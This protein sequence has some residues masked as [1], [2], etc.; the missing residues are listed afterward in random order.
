MGRS[1]MPKFF[2][3]QI[4]QMSIFWSG[5]NSKVNGFFIGP[6]GSLP[7]GRAFIPRNT[8]I[9]TFVA[10]I[11]ALFVMGILLLSYDTQIGQLVIGS[12]SIYVINLTFRK[13]FIDYCPNKSMSF[14]HFFAITNLNISIRIKTFNRLICAFTDKNS[15]NRIVIKRI[16]QMLNIKIFHAAF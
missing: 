16:L 9:P 11:F 4:C 6:N 3:I 15:S 10:S 7:F 5:K 1:R 14:V 2:G 13:F 12:I 8:N